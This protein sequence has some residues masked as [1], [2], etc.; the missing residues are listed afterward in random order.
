MK[1]ICSWCK[2][3][4]KDEGEGNEISHGI[5]E[6]CATRQEVIYTLELMTRYGYGRPSV[7]E[8]F[9]LQYAINELKK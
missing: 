5:C 3:V 8:K 7:E 1:T 4:I 2:K 6:R 9:A